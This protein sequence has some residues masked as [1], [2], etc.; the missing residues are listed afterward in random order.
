MHLRLE[1][2]S[3]VG[4]LRWFLQGIIYEKYFNHWKIYHCVQINQIYGCYFIC[5]NS[6]QIWVFLNWWFY[7]LLIQP[8]YLQIIS[9]FWLE[10]IN[11]LKKLCEAT[12][13]AAVWKYLGGG[14]L[15]YFFFGSEGGTAQ[16]SLL[17]FSLFSCCSICPPWRLMGPLL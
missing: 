4:C 9:I 5:D 15:F 11:C 14:T 3:G 6:I 1:F 16:F 8:I 10:I 2:D 12:Y 7:L 13:T 17:L